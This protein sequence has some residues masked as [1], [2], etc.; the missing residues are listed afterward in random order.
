MF[1]K[2]A[3]GLLLAAASCF[4]APAYD[5]ITYAKEK[6][7]AVILGEYRDWLSTLVINA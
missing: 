7:P 5:G 2:L 1:I 3:L 4:A 6:L